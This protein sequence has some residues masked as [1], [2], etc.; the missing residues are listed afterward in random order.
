[1]SSEMEDNNPETSL[2]ALRAH[3][4]LARHWAGGLKRAFCDALQAISKSLERLT[5]NDGQRRAGAGLGKYSI[6]LGSLDDGQFISGRGPR[7]MC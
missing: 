4:R 6:H 2:N 3:I 7:C 5:H 1:M